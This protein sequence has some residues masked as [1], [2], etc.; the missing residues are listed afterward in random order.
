M[1]RVPIQPVFQVSKPAAPTIRNPN[2]SRSYRPSLPFRATALKHGSEA[3]PFSVVTNGYLPPNSSLPDVNVHGRG[4]FAPRSNHTGGAQLAMC[5]G[6]V[7]MINNSIDLQT[8]W[9]LFS[10]NG[11]EVIWRCQLNPRRPIEQRKIRH[12]K[13]NYIIR[14]MSHQ[15]SRS[16]V[17]PLARFKAATT[18]KLALCPASFGR[19]QAP[20]RFAAR[21]CN[22]G[23]QWKL[24]TEEVAGLPKLDSESSFVQMEEVDGV[25]VVEFTINKMALSKAAGSLSIRESSRMNMVITFTGSFRASRESQ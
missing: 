12:E 22:A 18:A 13:P 8:Q 5:D 3:L 11:G 15:Q 23:D 7:R 2:L 10:R 17:L 25:L 20:L 19:S 4:W 24:V 16:R 6:S 14:R 9:A 21:T 1:D